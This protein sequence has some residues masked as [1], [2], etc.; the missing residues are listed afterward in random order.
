MRLFDP[1]R[2]IVN[3]LVVLTIAL[4][5][6]ATVFATVS[7]FTFRSARTAQSTLKQA[8][9]KA[10]EEGKKE[11]AELDAK[12]ALEEA[13]SP[14]RSYTAPR[15]A[16]SFQL[17]FPK[18]WSAMADIGEDGDELEFTA[19]PDLLDVSDSEGAAY[20]LV[21]KLV[22]QRSSALLREYNEAAADKRVS[23]KAVR[24]SGV[25]AT[26]Y[27]GRYDDDHNGVIVIVPMRDRTLT[28]ETQDRQFINQ[29][30]QVLQ[31]SKLAP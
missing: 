6:A 22:N 12:K 4:G 20:A 2:G 13:Q 9:A 27:E 18:N 28:F 24:V 7:F 25:A 15:S 19:H 21:V 16:G 31:Q 11:Q 1:Q 8:S 17:R 3:H 14:Y 10:R 23:S 5:L 29:F 26:W 30:N